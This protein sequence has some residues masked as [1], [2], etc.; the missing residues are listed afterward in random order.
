MST[1]VKVKTQ[2][3]ARV[4]VNASSGSKNISA[5]SSG[6]TRLDQLFDVV[7]TNET[8]KATLVYDA[9]T[10]K[11]VVQPLEFSDITGDLDGGTF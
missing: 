1:V 8:D 7:A 9:V 5:S 4:S 11:Y 3:I 2:N 6:V 10:D